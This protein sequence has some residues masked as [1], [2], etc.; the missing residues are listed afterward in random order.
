MR[1]NT[2]SSRNPTGTNSAHPSMPPPNDTLSS[3]ISE[4]TIRLWTFISGVR[5][6]AEP[7]A[8]PGG[9]L[10]RRARRSAAS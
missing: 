7:S 6:S 2:G 1:S 3:T 8:M 9:H 4:K 10:P 5:P